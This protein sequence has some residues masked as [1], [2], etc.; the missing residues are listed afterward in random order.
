MNKLIFDI[1]I[2]QGATYK[3]S[4]EYRDKYDQPINLTGCTYAM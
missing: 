1:Y 4:L 3:L 2:K